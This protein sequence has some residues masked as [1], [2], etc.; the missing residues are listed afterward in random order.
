[1]SQPQRITIPTADATALGGFLWRHPPRARDGV[2]EPAGAARGG[3]GCG[4][5]GG[6]GLV[7]INAATSVRCRYYS[8]FAEYLHGHGF[9]VLTYDYRGIGESRPASMRGF[10][11]SWMDWGQKDFEAV[12]TYARR[13]FP[14]QP[15]DVAAHSIGGF[16]TGLAPSSHACGASSPWGAVRLLARL[17][18][19]TPAAHAG[20]MAPGHAGPDRLPGLLSAGGWAGWRTRR[21]AWCA[22]GVSWGRAS[23]RAARRPTARIRAWPPWRR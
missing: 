9:D 8:R 7:I 23:R 17:R 22:T 11:A 18:A 6:P 5:D 20:Q 3:H 16:V 4:R 13:E 12:L 21:A 19:G 15:V 1:M 10:Q 2:A 14:G